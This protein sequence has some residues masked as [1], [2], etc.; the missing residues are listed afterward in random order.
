MNQQRPEIPEDLQILAKKIV[1]TESACIEW[2]A[3]AETSV[4]LVAEQLFLVRQAEQAFCAEKCA[5]LEAENRTLRE[6]RSKVLRLNGRHIDYLMQVVAKHKIELKMGQSLIK[7]VVEA[8]EAQL[9][10]M[11]RPVTDEEWAGNTGGSP[12]SLLYEVHGWKTINEFIA[13]R[14]GDTGGGN[15]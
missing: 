12:W 3:S 6:A 7:T 9:E 15:G 2:G 5:R 1:S 10:A 4:N 11:S 8:L 14:T 13:A